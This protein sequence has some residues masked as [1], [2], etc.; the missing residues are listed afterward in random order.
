MWAKLK[1][2]Q[3]PRRL[4]HSGKITFILAHHGRNKLES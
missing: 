1:Y 2:H 3:H 4:P